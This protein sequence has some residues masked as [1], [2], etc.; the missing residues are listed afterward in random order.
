MTIKISCFAFATALVFAN[1]LSAATVSLAPTVDGS[2]IQNGG[3][4]FGTD[5]TSD[6]V[7]LQ[8]SG[9]L[10]QI[11]VFEFDL[12]SINLAAVTAAEFVVA[13]AGPHLQAPGGITHFFLE[14]YGG[15]GAVT[16]SDLSAA[17]TLLGAFDI[18]DLN[19]GGFNTEWSFGIDPL[20]FL[21]LGGGLVTLRLGV[22]DPDGF[23]G[24][25]IFTNESEFIDRNVILPGVQGGTPPRLNFTVAA[26]P[27]P[28]SL[29][30]LLAG[31]GGMVMLRR[32]RSA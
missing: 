1:S 19:A 21:G 29:P 7:L 31:L 27:L 18:G 2:V 12:S 32:R 10:S 4:A 24:L 25:S 9:P 20:F 23:T 8:V 13:Q 5:S 11:G 3:A 22:S 16:I 28:A 14:G 15:D 6:G 17:G 30:L 26:V